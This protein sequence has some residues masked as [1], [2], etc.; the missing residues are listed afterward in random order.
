[1]NCIKC[2]REIPE[3][4]VFCPFCGEKVAA[5]CSACGAELIDDSEFCRFCG[6]KVE[7]GAVPATPADK[8]EWSVLKN[9]TVSI[10]E[11]N[12]GEKK[13]VIPSIISGRRVSRISSD[14]FAGEPLVSITIP[15][16]VE[17]IDCWAFSFCKALSS[18][19]IYNG[20]KIIDEF[21]FCDCTSLTSINLPDSVTK[22]GQ[23]A[24]KGCASLK[25]ITFSENLTEIGKHTFKGCT[26]LTSINLHDSVKIGKNAFKGTP[27]EDNFK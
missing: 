17:T 8:F 3:D 20:V 16:S 19:N 23:G 13:V 14:S 1:M 25:S 24:F 27:L 11:Y 15:E 26:S 6:A 21:A 2:N 4:S 18:V 5:A 9:G 7:E 10:D 22:I 12:R